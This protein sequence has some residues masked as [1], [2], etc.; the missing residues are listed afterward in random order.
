MFNDANSYAFFSVFSEA[1][2]KSSFCNKKYNIAIE[3]CEMEHLHV[4]I[5]Y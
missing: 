1:N 5:G 4:S 2:A 3:D